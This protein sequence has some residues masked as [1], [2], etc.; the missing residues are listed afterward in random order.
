MI[1]FLFYIALGT[2]SVELFSMA[3]VSRFLEKKSTLF[4][5]VRILYP[6]VLVSLIL[7][8]NLLIGRGV[9]HFFEDTKIWYAATILLMLSVKYLYNARNQTQAK[10]SINPL[11]PKGLF[12]LTL[13]VGIDAFFV[14]LAFGLTQLPISILGFGILMLILAEILGYLWGIVAKRLILKQ[15]DWAAFAIFLIIAII[16]VVKT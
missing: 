13:L 8:S 5:F 9:S 16:L 11:D 10:R 14:G 15:F 2:L 7:W 4:S 1:Q 6:A 3:M 12:I